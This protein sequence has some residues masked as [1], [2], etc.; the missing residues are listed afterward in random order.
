[1]F[2]EDD[3]EEIS[4]DVVNQLGALAINVCISSVILVGF[5]KR[6]SDD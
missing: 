5:C 3:G 2:L 6:L 1:M 4:H